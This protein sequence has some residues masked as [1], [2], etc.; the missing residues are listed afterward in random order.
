MKS[1]VSATLLYQMKTSL[2]EADFSVALKKLTFRAF[3]VQ[4]R[5]LLQKSSVFWKLGMWLPLCW[6]EALRGHSAVRCARLPSSWSKCPIPDYLAVMLVR[7]WLCKS[8]CLST[9]V[10]PE[11]KPQ[12]R[13]SEE[14]LLPEG[15]RSYFQ[16]IF[17]LT[18]LSRVFHVFLQYFFLCFVCLLN[19]EVVTV[20]SVVV[21]D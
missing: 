16:I 13:N 19:L 21:L 2:V 10:S 1:N 9:G 7:S 14:M 15:C 3:P 4:T 17:V 5:I 8:Y 12:K 18:N 11:Q 20:V 6:W